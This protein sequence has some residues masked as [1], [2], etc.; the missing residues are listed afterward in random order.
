MLILQDAIST[1]GATVMLAWCTLVWSVLSLPRI[2]H[3]SGSSGTLLWKEL[4]RFVLLS[5][6]VHNRS[7]R[8]WRCQAY[9]HR[10]F[11]SLSPLHRLKFWRPLYDS[12]RIIGTP[13]GKDNFPLYGGRGWSKPLP[14]SHPSSAWLVCLAATFMAFPAKA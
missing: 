1:F 6:L 4:P 3:W 12:L 5:L 8:R 14:H 9:L 13:S 2:S 10:P 7:C 11:P